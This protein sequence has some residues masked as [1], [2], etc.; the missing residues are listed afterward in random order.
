[1]AE[2]PAPDDMD[3]SLPWPG[4]SADGTPAR[5]RPEVDL[6]WRPGAADGD[7][8]PDPRSVRR[9]ILVRVGE[10]PTVGALRAEL[11]ALRADVDALRS[12]VAALSQALAE[13][14]V[15]G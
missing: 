15:D 10:S 13:G 12:E 7:V 4:G 11:E 2:Q 6:G 14:C 9:G 8:T 3:V 1:M 5:P